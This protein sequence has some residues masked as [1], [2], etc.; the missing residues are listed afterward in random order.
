MSH[1]HSAGQN[2][3]VKMA[4]KSFGNVTKFRHFGMQ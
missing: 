2:H 3:N 1:H 4:N